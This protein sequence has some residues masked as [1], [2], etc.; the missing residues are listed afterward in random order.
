MTLHTTPVCVLSLVTVAALAG[1]RAPASVR[2]GALRDAEGFAT[3]VTAD[4]FAT[5]CM[6]LA[7][8]TRTEWDP[9]PRPTARPPKRANPVVPG[10]HVTPEP[11]LIGAAVVTRCTG[12]KGGAARPPD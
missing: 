9:T 8:G 12:V 11:R 4:Q 6:D 7:P 3:S 1:C 10:D 2:D 5:A